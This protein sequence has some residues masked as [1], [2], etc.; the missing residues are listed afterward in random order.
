M[1]AEEVQVP[2]H[3]FFSSV[4]SLCLKLLRWV[5]LDDSFENGEQRLHRPVQ[6]LYTTSASGLTWSQLPQFGPKQCSFCLTQHYQS[7]WG[8]LCSQVYVNCSSW[9]IA[10]LHHLHN[11]EHR[12]PLCDACMCCYYF[13]LLAASYLVGLWH[14]VTRKGFLNFEGSTCDAGKFATR[15][16]KKATLPQRQ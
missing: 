2:A 13:L 16:F 3:E 15:G 6:S 9:V 7:L 1:P 8:I 10:P 12:L 14:L 11:R 4:S 5:F